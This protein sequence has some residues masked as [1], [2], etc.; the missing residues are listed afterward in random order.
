MSD[1][2]TLMLFGGVALAVLGAGLVLSN[3][4]VRGLLGGISAG[5][6]LQAVVPDFDRYLK[7]RAM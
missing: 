1:R 6:L 2:D 3:R 5:G 4:S 7:L